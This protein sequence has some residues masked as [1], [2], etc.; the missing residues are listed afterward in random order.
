MCTGMDIDAMLTE[1]IQYRIINNPRAT[2]TFENY[3]GNAN[4]FA[5]SYNVKDTPAQRHPV[6]KHWIPLDPSM[7]Q[8]RESIMA[9]AVLPLGSLEVRKSMEEFATNARIGPKNRCPRSMLLY[10]PHGVGKTHLAQAVANATGALFIN[11]S[12]GNTDGK[13]PEKGGQAKLLHMAFEVAKDPAFGPVVIYIDEV[14]KM[15]PGPPPKGKPKPDP[16][17]PAR[18]KKELPIYINSLTVD[19]SVMVIGCTSEPE[20]AD[21]KSLADCFDRFIYI[22]LPDYGTRLQIWKHELENTFSIVP[23]VLPSPFTKNK[24]K[25][26]ETTTTTTTTN[27]ENTEAT[28]T[29][30]NE[31]SN[32]TNSNSNIGISIHGFNA[33]PLS[34]TTTYVDDR[35]AHPLLDHLNITAL[36]T[37]SNG[38]PVGSIREAIRLAC[39]LRRL[40]ALDTRPIEEMDFINTLSRCSRVYTANIEILNDFT[41]K[42]TGLETARVV[43][44]ASAAPA[45]KK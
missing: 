1:L 30:T 31:P 39:T 5:S 13:L 42:I 14:E 11:L 37:I 3:Y 28:P 32:N 41:A 12:S 17:G 36:A 2:A 44:E 45:K 27:T 25:T 23:R 10:G 19:H 22:P 24:K 16:N 8:V 26:T 20:V 18:F 9:N 4:M 29:E 34:P 43:P 35:V 38:Y 15:I 6:T 21:P 40:D 33:L 7:A